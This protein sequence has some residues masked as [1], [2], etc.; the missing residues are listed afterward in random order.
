MTWHDSRNGWGLCWWQ[1]HL[2]GPFWVA[3]EHGNKEG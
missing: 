2:E 1:L 3:W